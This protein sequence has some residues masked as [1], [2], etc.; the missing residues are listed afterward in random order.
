MLL[1]FNTSCAC[2]AMVGDSDAA[3]HAHHEQHAGDT[4]PGADCH[5]DCED[6][7]KAAGVGLGKD[8]SQP[9]SF[10]FGLDDI[11]WSAID[12]APYIVG[13]T[14]SSTGPPESQIFPAANTPVR[15]F[16][17]QIE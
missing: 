16:D 10:K 17:L 9:P 4:A 13:G 3:S 7:E 14:T 15:R 1:V 12:I 11:E 6:C 2:A 8:E 5:T